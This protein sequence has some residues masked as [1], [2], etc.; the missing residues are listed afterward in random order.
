MWPGAEEAEFW[1][2]AQALYLLEECGERGWPAP[3]SL[4]ANCR[5]FLGRRLDDHAALLTRN[6][7]SLEPGE[8]R[9]ANGEDAA[10]AC[11]ALAR[12]DA[13]RRSWLVRMNQIAAERAAEGRP[14]APQALAFLCHA[15][16]L[17]GAPVRAR[18]LFDLHGPGGSAAVPAATPFGNAAWLAAGLRLGVPRA[19]LA[20]TAARLERELPDSYVRWSTR[21][22]V[23]ALLALG[24]YWQRFRPAP[25][26]RARLTVNGAEREFALSAG[27]NW[28]DLLP[29]AVVEAEALG[30]DPLHLVWTAE[31]VPA[32]GEA[33]EEDIGMTARRSVLDPDGKPL[34]APY[35]LRQGEVYRIRLEIAGEADDL[36]V[37]DL[38][39]AGLEVE[40]PRL[41]GRDG[42]R[43][44]AL[45]VEQVERRDDRLLLFG[46]VREKGV[47]EYLCRAVTPGAY[48][49]PALDA[50]RMYDSGVRSVHGE[51][52]L[53]VE[54]AGKAEND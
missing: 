2:S 53:V 21:E 12:G 25:E 14:L 19:A 16:L 37:A 5:D 11:L 42:E 26:S 8:L 9:Y 6:P 24:T 10:L 17:A 3:E 47:Y 45:H 44:D 51:G 4:L 15:T 46:S 35:V 40:N 27:A 22:N 31:G 30:A 32:S 38:L 18:E 49:W 33:R 43:A 52:R 54:A 34:K 39:P 28:P 41:K 23:W 50:G 29:G 1:L 36:V 20:P 7:Q 48:V 13:L